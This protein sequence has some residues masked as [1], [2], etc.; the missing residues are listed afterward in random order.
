MG[1]AVRNVNLETRFSKQLMALYGYRAR[2]LC[3]LQGLDRRKAVTEN[4]HISSMR[5]CMLEREP[6]GLQLAFQRGLNRA[7][8]R[9]FKFGHG[10][11]RAVDFEIYA[12]C[13]TPYFASDV[14]RGPFLDP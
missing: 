5:Y 2:Q 14:L 1:K 10:A 3:A 4:F 7:G 9:I 8:V 11:V 13:G 6:D 12:G